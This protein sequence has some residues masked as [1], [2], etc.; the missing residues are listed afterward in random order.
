VEIRLQSPYG[1]ITLRVDVPQTPHPHPLSSILARAG[2]LLHGSGP[3]SPIQGWTS[4]T[5][6]TKIPALSLIV[7]TEGSPPLKLISEWIFPSR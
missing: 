2:D 1:W 7:K 4:P 3:V 5:Y 6:G